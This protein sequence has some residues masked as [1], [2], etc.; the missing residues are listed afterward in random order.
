MAE[1]ASVSVVVGDANKCATSQAELSDFEP[2]SR[3]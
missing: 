3:W 1:L 2:Q